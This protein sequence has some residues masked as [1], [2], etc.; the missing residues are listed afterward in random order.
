MGVA[1]Y[2]R[3]Y[4]GC[5]VLLLFNLTMLQKYLRE[6]KEMQDKNIIVL[7]FYQRLYVLFSL[8]YVYVYVNVTKTAI[9]DQ[10]YINFA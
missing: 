2:S 3:N 1:R 10:S 9:F 4:S 7:T 6:R 8:F 5:N